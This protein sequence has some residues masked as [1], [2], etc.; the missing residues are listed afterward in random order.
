MII[1][2]SKYRFSGW[3]FN[4]VDVIH[5][6]GAR[7]MYVFDDKGVVGGMYGRDFFRLDHIFDT[8]VE[9]LKVAIS[10]CKSPYVEYH[11]ERLA[12]LEKE[13]SHG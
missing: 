2:T 5:A 4:N 12:E 13:A 11:K 6:E 7:I 3:I 1:D 8:E 10:I 9:A